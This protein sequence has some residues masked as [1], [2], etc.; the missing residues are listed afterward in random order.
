MKE[1]DV[2]ELFKAP[3]LLTRTMQPRRL[4]KLSITFG[5]CFDGFTTGLP[6]LHQ[7]AQQFP[8]THVTLIAEN[9]SLMSIDIRKRDGVVAFV[10]AKHRIG[11]VLAL[12]DLDTSQRTWRVFP[13]IFEDELERIQEALRYEGFKIGCDWIKNGI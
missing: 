7:V 11:K 4:A 1:R 12:Y 10:E 3:K 6:V 9:W 5:V 13:R 8:N 2:A